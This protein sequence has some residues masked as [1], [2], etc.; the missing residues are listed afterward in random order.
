MYIVK[1]KSLFR[2]KN[3]KGDLDGPNIPRKIDTPGFSADDLISD[4]CFQCNSQ[5]VA[6]IVF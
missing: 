2:L 5:D 1:E 3:G 4:F 6:L